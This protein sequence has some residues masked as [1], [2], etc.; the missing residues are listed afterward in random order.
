MSFPVVVI[1]PRLMHAARV[2]VV[3]PCVCMCVCVCSNLPPHTLESFLILPILLKM[4][5]LKVMV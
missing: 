1:N 5:R 4:L 2:T 3:V